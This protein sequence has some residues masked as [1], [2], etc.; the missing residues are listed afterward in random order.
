MLRAAGA[1]SG[2]EV[3]GVDQRQAA[4]SLLFRIKTSRAESGYRYGS[5][6]IRGILPPGTNEKKSK[7]IFEKN[8][9]KHLHF[10]KKCCN[11]SKYGSL[12]KRLRRRPLTAETGVRFPYELLRKASGNAKLCGFSKLF[13]FLQIKR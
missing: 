2:N 13:Y 10:R 11:I 6:K 9:K 8:L 3:S 7:K 5:L 1:V 4:K 12:V